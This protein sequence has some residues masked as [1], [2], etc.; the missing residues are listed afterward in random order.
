MEQAGGHFHDRHGAPYSEFVTKILNKLAA[1][2]NGIE[3]LDQGCPYDT[4]KQADG[5]YEPPYFLYTR[6]NGVSQRI[7]P[8][9]GANAPSQRFLYTSKLV[10]EYWRDKKTPP[11]TRD[12]APRV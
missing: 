2:L 7:S 11:M 12:T 3:Q 5:R 1:R 6:L 8:Y 4:Q 9:L 10:K